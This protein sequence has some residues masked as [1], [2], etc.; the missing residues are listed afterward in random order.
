[1]HTFAFIGGNNW[2]AILIE[3]NRVLWLTPT[4]DKWQATGI[5]NIHNQ[6]AFE[7]QYGSS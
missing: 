6:M 2:D 5:E 7:R 1:M 4:D 3:H